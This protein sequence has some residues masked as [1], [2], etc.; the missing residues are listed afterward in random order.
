[1]DDTFYLFLRINVSLDTSDFLPHRRLG[2]QTPVDRR[3]VCLSSLIPA[4]VYW[5]LFNVYRFSR[6]HTIK[7]EKPQ[8]QRHFFWVV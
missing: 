2:A 7:I 8:Q 4:N 6:H 5:L 1:M 3:L